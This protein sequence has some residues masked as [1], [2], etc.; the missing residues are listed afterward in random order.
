MSMYYVGN[1]S[2]EITSEHS[3]VLKQL[4]AQ[5]SN[6]LNLTHY[7]SMVRCGQII[8]PKW[9][10]PVLEE[11][12]R[13]Y[14]DDYAPDAERMTIPKEDLTSFKKLGDI[15]SA[16]VGQNSRKSEKFVTT[17]QAK[18]LSETYSSFLSEFTFE[19]QYIQDFH[20]NGYKLPKSVLSHLITRVQEGIEN[21]KNVSYRD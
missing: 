6:K 13:W 21:N 15:V 3:R 16:I 19:E 8:D 9:L 7:V 1:T 17:T 5:V 12:E 20:R 18:E 4:V 14:L 2:F 10:A 11:L